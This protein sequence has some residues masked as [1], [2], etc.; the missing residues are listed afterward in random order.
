MVGE[1]WNNSREMDQSSLTPVAGFGRN[2]TGNIESHFCAARAGACS[3]STGDAATV[4]EESEYD[5]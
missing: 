4:I 2:L 1:C 3:T 5:Y